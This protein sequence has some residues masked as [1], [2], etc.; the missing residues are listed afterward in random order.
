MRV[1]VLD[2]DSVELD[3][4]DPILKTKIVCPCKGDSCSHTQ[5]FDRASFIDSHR[6]LGRRDARQDLLTQALLKSITTKLNV[7]Q[8]VCT[9]CV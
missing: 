9:A 8:Q 3:L 5:F 7:I 4:K 2:D 6:L 1:T